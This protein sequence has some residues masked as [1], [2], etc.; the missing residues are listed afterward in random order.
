MNLL[1]LFIAVFGVM[2]IVLTMLLLFSF[3]LTKFIL[4]PYKEDSNILSVNEMLSLLTFFME[5]EIELYEKDIFKT[6]K[7]LTNSSLE[8]YYLDITSVIVNNIPPQF[9]KKMK[10]YFSEEYIV[11]IVSR[12]VMNYLKNKITNG[13]NLNNATEI[14][15]SRSSN[16]TFEYEN[17]EI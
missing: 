1:Y 13:E 14:R 5:K 17:D 10:Y 7:P 15:H 9:M 8:N 2:F 3:I 12:M 16:E 4:T 6:N 11:S